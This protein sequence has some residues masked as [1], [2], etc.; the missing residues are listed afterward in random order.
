MATE[1]WE[2]IAHRLASRMM[3]H[4]YCSDCEETRPDDCP[5]C[6]DI[7]AYQRYVAKCRETGR[8]PAAVS[9][10]DNSPI[11]RLEDLMR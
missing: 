8:T 2:N 5:F 7:E 6:A 4:A 3:H 9:S 11:V 1:S 10:F